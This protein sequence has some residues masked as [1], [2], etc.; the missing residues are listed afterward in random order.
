MFT[1]TFWKQAAE[2]AVKSAA[3]AVIGLGILDGANVL[4]FDWQLAGGTAL[5]AVGLSLLSSIVTSG[6]G[7][8][9]DPSAVTKAD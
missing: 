7:E 2:R 4:H 5:G 1:K 3:Q 9:S 8:K 6:I